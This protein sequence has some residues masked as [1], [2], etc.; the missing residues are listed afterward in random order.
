LAG[1]L[2]KKKGGWETDVEIQLLGTTALQ[3]VKRTSESL[4]R[5]GT[6]KS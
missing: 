5:E 1:E 3:E 4:N 2:P 6:G